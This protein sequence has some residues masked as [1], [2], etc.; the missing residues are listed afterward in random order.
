[1]AV[2]GSILTATTTYAASGAGFL[3]STTLVPS[4][5]ILSWSPLGIV[6]AGL[7]SRRT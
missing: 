5:E 7:S 4:M 2:F 6:V 3:F 1:M